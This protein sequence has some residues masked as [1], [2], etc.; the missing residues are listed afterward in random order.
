MQREGRDDIADFFIYSI[1]AVSF[2]LIALFCEPRVA[3]ADD[4]G[5]VMINVTHQN[6]DQV[7]SPSEFVSVEKLTQGYFSV[8]DN[9]SDFILE[10]Q[11]CNWQLRSEN[12]FVIRIN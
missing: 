12:C 7:A 1:V 11:P 3:L 9:N 2:I 6:G 4:K 10:N 8:Y 5:I